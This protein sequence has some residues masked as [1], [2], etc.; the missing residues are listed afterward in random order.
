MR[1]FATTLMLMVLAAWT[2]PCLAQGLEVKAGSPVSIERLAVD[3]DVVEGVALVEVDE[4]FRNAAPSANEGVWKFRLPADSVVSSFSMWM[5]GKE[6]TGRVLE[7]K[8]ARQVYDSIVRKRRDPGLLEQTGWRD[9]QVSVFPIPA[10]GTVRVRLRYAYVLPDDLGLE[11]ME[12]PLPVGCGAVGDLRVHAKLSAARGLA[13]V[14]SPTHKDARISVA[15]GRAEATWSGDGAVPTGPFVVRAVPKRDGFDVAVVAHRPAGAEEGWF[16]ARVVPRLAAP[17]TIARDVVFVVDRSGSMEGVKMTQA[18]A[19]LLRG[20]DTL[21]AGDRFDVVSFSGD[22]TALKDGALLPVTDENLDAARRAAR[23]LS[24]SGGTNIAGALDAALALRSADASRLFV[25]VFLTD[26]DPTVGETRPEEILAAWRRKSA[27]AAR[28]FAFGV[29]AEVKDFLLTKLAT[30]GRGTA[31][32]VR[33]DEELEIKLSSLVDSI[34]T[35]LLVDP[36]VTVEGGGVEVL[37]R[38]PRRAADVFQGRALVVTG[39]YRGAGKATLRLRGTSGATAVDVAVPVDFAATSDRPYVAQIWAKARIERLLDDLRASGGGKEIR[40]EIVRLGLRHQIVTPYTSFLV[41]ED[42]VRIPD[43][44]ETARV[45]DGGGD[46]PTAPTAGGPDAGGPSSGGGGGGAPSTGGGGRGPST[47]GGSFG[48]R[49]PAGQVPPD[50]REPNDPPPAPEGSGPSTPGG[51]ASGAATNTSSAFKK[52][53]R[54]PG[55]E[56]WTWWWRRSWM[57]VALPA[58][59]HVAATPETLAALHKFLRDSNENF[60]VRSRAVLALAAMGDESIVPD[61]EHIVSATTG[62]DHREVIERSALALGFFAAKSSDVRTFLLDTL[63]DRANT[64]SFA[65]PFAAVALG[66]RRAGGAVDAATVRALFDVLDAEHDGDVRAACLLAIGSLGDAD[67][68][69]RLI[70]LL[71]TRD[72]CEASFV[73]DALGRIGRPGTADAGHADDVVDALANCLGL[74]TPRDL[75]AARSA[76]TA[77]ARIAPNAAAKTQRRIVDV[78]ATAI[79]DLPDATTRGWG[80]IALGRIAADASIDADA[81]ASAVDALE[82]CAKTKPAPTRA[83]ASIG[84]AFRTGTVAKSPPIAAPSTVDDLRAIASALDASA[85]DLVAQISDKDAS[86]ESLRTA[87]RAL[88][89]R[90]DAASVVALRAVAVDPDGAE[91]DLCRAYAVGAIGRLCGDFAPLDRV[92]AG[93]NFRAYVPAIEELMSM[94]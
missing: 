94:R 84:L 1:T 52:L 44:G 86:S 55:F 47:G 91:P 24:A 72:E 43:P 74:R 36:E 3:A 87:A 75:N 31:T 60:R 56:D 49:G 67:C 6:K 50:A 12:I 28:L 33:L 40:A 85:T 38:E 9:F 25:V 83:Y 26:G 88:G 32:Y 37:D 73:V 30:E 61:L 54:P 4:T 89:A 19:A 62:R 59:P 66:L 18:Q 13:T 65:R 35:P 11:T 68:A 80:L 41:V 17:P 27:G 7:A 51:E 90:G 2:T 53:Q 45:P 29:G 48:S 78:I 15:D 70:A 5:D 8:Q 23:D 57:D 21:K 42:G 58:S 93:L 20:L 16:V 82:R 63:R 92:V 14:D 10:H 69:P 71:P 79:D 22:V 81:R 39:R 77:L 76:T 34:R 64:G 46:G